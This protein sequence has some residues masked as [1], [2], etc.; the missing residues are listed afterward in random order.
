[1][2]MRKRFGISINRNKVSRK[3]Q[4]KRL[5]YIYAERDSF[6]LADDVMAP[7]AKNIPYINTDKVSD[8]MNIIINQYLYNIL[9]KD[10][11][12]VIKA[13]N[14]TIGYIQNLSGEE[15]SYELI[16][17][18]DYFINL[19]IKSIYCSITKINKT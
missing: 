8:V 10:I 19:K 1:M 17:P 16:I 3:L 5:Y 13:N 14:K 18:D 7:N 11:K 4:I 15:P 6:C 9:Y 12:W 2:I